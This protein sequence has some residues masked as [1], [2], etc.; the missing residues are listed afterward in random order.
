MSGTTNSGTNYEIRNI[1]LS[2]SSD[3]P[4][5][6]NQQINSFIIKARTSVDL[7]LRKTNND[8]GYFTIP[9]DQSLTVNCAIGDASQGGFI[10][11]Y[12]RAS[13]GSPVAEVIG[14]F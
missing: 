6:F 4:I 13:T 10:V 12:L 3:T 5:D 8:S 11:G 14:V 7:Y 9:A 1:T 2:S